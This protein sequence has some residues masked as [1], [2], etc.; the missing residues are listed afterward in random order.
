[1]HF[2]DFIFMP[3][4]ALCAT[5]VTVYSNGKKAYCFPDVPLPEEL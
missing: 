4:K 1:M 3:L 2:S 5:F